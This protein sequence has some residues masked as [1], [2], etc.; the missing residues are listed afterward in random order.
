MGPKQKG[1]AA[2]RG[3]ATEEVEET[4]QAVVCYIRIAEERLVVCGFELMAPCDSRCLRILLRR[5]SSRSHL[6]SLGY[7]WLCCC[8]DCMHRWWG[9]LKADAGVI[10]LVSLAACEHSLD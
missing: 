8:V 2:K 6:R 1:G 7:V 5:G 3:N 4:L 9:T 10:D